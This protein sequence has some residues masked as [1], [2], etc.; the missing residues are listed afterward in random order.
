MVISG[1]VGA[2]VFCLSSR[3]LEALTVS[4]NAMA[5]V[6]WIVFALSLSHQARKTEIADERAFL[7]RRRE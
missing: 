2:L 1:L 3:T 6:F 5:F 7:A 4:A